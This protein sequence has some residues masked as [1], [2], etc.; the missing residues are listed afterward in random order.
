MNLKKDISKSIEVK[1]ALEDCRSRVYS[2]ALVHQKVFENKNIGHLNFKEYLSQLTKDIINSY[3]GDGNTVL[4]IASDDVTLELS[5]AI[6][7]GLIINEQ[8]TN[9]FK[10]AK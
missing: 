3:D 6:P 1:S 10:Y 5:T 2:M 4:Y 8:L 7:C 9:S